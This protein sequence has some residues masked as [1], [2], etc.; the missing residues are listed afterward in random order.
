MHRHTTQPS[1]LHEFGHPN[2]PDTSHSRHTFAFETLE[3]LLIHHYTE[4]MEEFLHVSD[5]SPMVLLDHESKIGLYVI[6]PR[7][8][9]KNRILLEKSARRNDIELRR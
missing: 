1:K 6:V 4:W 5:A 7:F 2:M 9:K 3:G 8:S